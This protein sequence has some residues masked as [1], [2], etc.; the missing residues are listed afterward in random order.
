M[1]AEVF[2]SSSLNFKACSPNKQNSGIEIIPPLKH[3]I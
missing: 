1:T 3:A 2:E